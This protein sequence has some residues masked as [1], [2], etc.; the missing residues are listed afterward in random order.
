M[1]L[2]RL[3]AT[4]LVAPFAIAVALFLLLEGGCRVVGRVRSGSWPESRAEAYREAAASDGWR[5][6]LEFFAKHLGRA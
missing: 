2:L 4:N 6:A 5:R 1:K 3:L